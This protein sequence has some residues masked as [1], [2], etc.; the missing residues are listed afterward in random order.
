MQRACVSILP[1]QA[2]LICNTQSQSP[3][4]YRLACLEHQMMYQFSMAW[5]LGVAQKYGR[6]TTARPESPDV[7]SRLF[8]P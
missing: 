2:E 5:P 7:L 3:T 1:T 6:I 4:L 8:R